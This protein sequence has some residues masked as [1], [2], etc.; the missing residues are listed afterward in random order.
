MAECVHVGRGRHTET[1]WPADLQTTGEWQGT[2]HAPALVAIL[3]LGSRPFEPLKWT[4]KT[5][6][7]I[8]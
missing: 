1:A 6:Q 2:H 7:D 5:K 8:V 3:S 4:K